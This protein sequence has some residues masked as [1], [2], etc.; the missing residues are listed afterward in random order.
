MNLWSRDCKRQ[1]QYFKAAVAI[2]EER[3]FDNQVM[4]AADLGLVSELQELWQLVSFWM[5]QPA[6]LTTGEQQILKSVA[7]V[8]TKTELLKDDEGVETLP[9]GLVRGDHLAL[10]KK[11]SLPDWRRSHPPKNILIPDKNILDDN[12]STWRIPTHEVLLHPF[13]Q[14]SRRLIKF[15]TWLDTPVVLKKT[16]SPQDKEVKAM[17]QRRIDLNHPNILKL[18]GVC[19]GY[20]V[21][22]YAA[23]GTLSDFLNQQRVSSGGKSSKLVWQKLLEAA[24]GL[25]YLHERGLVH[26][27]V[28]A[29]NLLVSNDGIVKLA[30]FGGS[31]TLQQRGTGDKRLADD[32]FAFGTCNIQLIDGHITPEKWGKIIPQQPQGFTSEQWRLVRHIR[33]P[34]PENRLPIGAVVHDIKRLVDEPSTSFKPP[35]SNRSLSVLFQDHLSTLRQSLLSDCTNKEYSYELEMYEQL[36]PR[37]SDIADQLVLEAPSCADESGRSRRHGYAPHSWLS[38]VS[39]FQLL[40]N[41]LSGYVAM[42]RAVRLAIGR[43]NAQS[44]Y[45]LHRELDQLVSTTRLHK[46]V[47]A[48]AR[49]YIHCQWEKQWYTLRRH[50]AQV[51][52]Q[53]MS[54]VPTILKEVEE[55]SS[56][57]KSGWT[58]HVQGFWAV[59]EFERL[60]YPTEYTAEELDT[61][62][63][64]ALEIADTVLDSKSTLPKWFLPP[65]EVDLK[66][67]KATLGRGAF[68]SVHRGTWLDSS[69][70]IKRVLGPSSSRDGTTTPS[71]GEVIF[72]HEAD[73][74]SRL[75]HPHV[76]ALYGAC[77]VGEPFFVCEYATKGTRLMRGKTVVRHSI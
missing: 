69:V 70:V 11:S 12:T 33:N 6:R 61:I 37:L 1:L 42:N 55:D 23:H 27:N 5:K 4:E 72:K 75:N 3:V 58:R 44:V 50:Q 41:E 16:V 21:Y 38:I 14:Q 34:D 18:Y 49:K 76:I 68:G 73:I 46:L 22:E 51:L 36:L 32:V 35:P 66:V 2:E 54:D 53:Q 74:W 56:T 52:C 7:H 67:N 71:D 77:H 43:K 25:Q 57:S 48:A 15:G 24:Q 59:L 19:D 20:Y 10:V 31:G 30:G 45:E 29:K 62:R 28:T 26:G 64:T 65:Y 13:T 60:R 63:H 9:T 39:R 17:A 8:M 47:E 40:V